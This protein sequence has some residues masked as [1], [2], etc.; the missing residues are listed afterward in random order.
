MIYYAIFLAFLSLNLTV[1]ARPDSH[2]PIGVMRDHVHNASEWMLSYRVGYMPMTGN[3]T[4]TTPQ[5]IDSVLKEYAVAPTAMP[6]T[7]HMVGGMLG[8]TD[9]LTVS[10]MG[11]YANRVMDHERRTGAVFERENGGMTD[12]SIN[13]LYELY[14][15]TQS[16]LQVNTG[17][18]VPTGAID[19]RK[20]DG[21]LFAYPMQLGSGTYD[22]LP[23]LSYTTEYDAWSWGGQ[24]NAVIRLGVNNRN[25]TLGNKYQIT[26]W[27]ARKLSDSVSLSL[28]LDGQVQD[29]IRGYD[30]ELAGP[31]FMAP[32]A[33]ANLH[34][35]ERL[36]VLVGL[37]FLGQTGILADHRLA[38]EFGVPVYERV[39]GPRLE[40]DYRLT[41]GW[42][43]AF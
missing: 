40:T 31:I 14:S 24:T 19:D 1:L 16:R 41:L 27:G 2:A 34:A 9:N 11:G 23:G 29:T 42:Q 6:M 22:V 37:N 30:T 36:D 3:L 39:D 15:N 5:S 8:I 12:T 4:G 10:V 7:M 38:A 33:D 13:L 43:R 25:Y 18:S 17:V 35:R 26:A 21:T 20:P 28:R 32:P